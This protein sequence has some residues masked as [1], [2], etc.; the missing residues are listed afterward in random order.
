MGKRKL[1]DSWERREGGNPASL[2]DPPVATATKGSSTLIRKRARNPNLEINVDEPVPATESSGG[3]DPLP[4]GEE[5]D[6]LS[7]WGQG[8]EEIPK[9]PKGEGVSTND[10]SRLRAGKRGDT[11]SEP[12]NNRNSLAQS[13]G[14]RIIST[15]QTD[16]LQVLDHPS[17][18]RFRRSLSRMRANGIEYSRMELMPP[19]IQTQIEFVIGAQL[20]G[21]KEASEDTFFQQLFSVVRPETGNP[22]L[23]LDLDSALRSIPFDCSCENAQRAIEYA[24]EVAKLFESDLDVKISAHA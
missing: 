3:E 12:H 4:D 22:D 11:H 14:T 17:L 23:R 7:E 16:M 19:E 9:E 5:S 1:I 13:P 15:M 21:W 2:A 8:Q 20:P 24:G 18:L 10:V 6:T